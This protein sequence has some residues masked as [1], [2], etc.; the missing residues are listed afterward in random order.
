MNNPE[1]QHIFVDTLRGS[2]VQFEDLNQLA[3]QSFKDNENVVSML[4]WSNMLLVLTMLV[5]S[6]NCLKYLYLQLFLMMKV[7]LE[8][9]Y[10]FNKRLICQ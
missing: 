5:K 6:M 9:Q 8:Y 10:K 1:T 3:P 4:V 2:G 7:L